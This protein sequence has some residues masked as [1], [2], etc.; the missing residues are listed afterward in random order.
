LQHSH[1]PQSNGI[2]ERFNRTAFE[3]AAALL[4]M[5]AFPATWWPLALI[6]WVFIHNGFKVGSDGRTPHY[7]R[8]EC[9]AEYTQYA[10]G[11]LVFVSPRKKG[12]KLSKWSDRMCPYIFLGYGIGP[13]FRWNKTYAVVPLRRLLGEHRPSRT[14]IRYSAE[15]FFPPK[16]SFP[17]K[18][19]L[20]LMGAARDGSFPAPSV[21]DEQKALL[22]IE[23]SDHE[24]GSEDE[25]YDGELGE[26][27]PKMIRD[28]LIESLIFEPEDQAQDPEG[29]ADPA[30][31]M[32]SSP[33]AD[34]LPLHLIFLSRALCQKR[35]M[36]LRVG[37]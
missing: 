34:P 36:P 14:T 15:V 18:Q 21:C 27:A 20:Q 24:A 17:C 12:V 5:A 7:R 23:A 9:D 3:G 19:R 37:E 28:E 11:S 35:L 16:V 29:E 13:E 31:E 26:N 8:F 25:L 32:Q 33:V 2:I 22:D 10:F 6:C 1:V 30:E 4:A